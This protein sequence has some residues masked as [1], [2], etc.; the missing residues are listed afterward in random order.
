MTP[1]RELAGRGGG[2]GAGRWLHRWCRWR[3]RLGWRVVEEPVHWIGPVTLEE[4][5][6]WILF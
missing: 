6:S 3:L 5:G 2:S 1:N 4:E